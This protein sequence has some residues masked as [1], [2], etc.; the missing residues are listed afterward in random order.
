MSYSGHPSFPSARIA[1]CFMVH[2]NAPK[3]REFAHLLGK[4]GHDVYIHLDASVAGLAREKFVAIVSEGAP[5][6]RFVPPFKCEWGSWNLV[7]GALSL[8]REVVA[9]GEPYSHVQLLS[10]ADLPTQSIASFGDF[11]MRNAR[12]DFME[13]VDISESKWVV[14]GPEKERFEYHFPFN[15]RSQR[16]R[17]DL[18][19][20]I[21]R[22]LRTKRRIPM[23]IKP[24]LGSQWW[25]LR[26]STCQKLIRFLKDHPKVIS[27]FQKTLIPDECFFQSLIP[28]LIDPNEIIPRT[29][30]LYKF[31]GYGKPFVF[32]DDHVE[33]LAG[34]P[35]FFARKVSPTAKRLE[36]SLFERAE[37]GP[38]PTWPDVRAGFHSFDLLVEASMAFRFK[39]PMVGHIGRS[40]HQAL[41]NPVR[42]CVI[43]V[44]QNREEQFGMVRKLGG[45]TELHCVDPFKL[46]P[47]LKIQGG[48]SP[49]FNSFL[50]NELNLPNQI[51]CMVT[52]PSGFAELVDGLWGVWGIQAI[53]GIIE[54]PYGTVDQR[55]LIESLSNH[56]QQKLWE[57]QPRPAGLP[58]IELPDNNPILSG[59]ADRFPVFL[60]GQHEDVLD[61]IRQ[62]GGRTLSW[63]LKERGLPDE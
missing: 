42:S 28:H 12:F 41:Q 17:F 57:K 50:A 5:Q 16:R 60:P 58:A 25:T 35:F 51:T 61:W 23:G 24:R 32:Y 62:A 56:E 46:P 4:L 59:E 1:F 31:T 55:K 14:H 27:Y 30:T 8:V 48:A 44:C 49:P 22:M 43:L 34:E 21:Q 47:L 6:A 9:S 37:K 39:D 15:W 19:F 7:E 63:V 29:L 38:A 18:V 45:F 53:C 33:M 3:I 11:L 20:S 36:S 26:L 40:W 2:D 52:T 10:G 13:T 54:Y